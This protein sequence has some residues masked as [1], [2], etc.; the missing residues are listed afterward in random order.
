MVLVRGANPILSTH[1][2]PRPPT[3][4][5]VPEPTLLPSPLSTP[6]TVHHEGIVGPVAQP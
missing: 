3:P 2:W 6:T 5:A 1:P 4:L